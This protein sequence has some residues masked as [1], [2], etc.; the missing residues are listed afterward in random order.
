MIS[1]EQKHL[2]NSLIIYTH[3]WLYGNPIAGVL[4]SV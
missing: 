4:R 2:I 1:L 3:L